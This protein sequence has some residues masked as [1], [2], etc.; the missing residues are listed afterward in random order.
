MS[1]LVVAEP[2]RA[3]R[4]RP[5]VVVDC[6]ALAAIIFDEPEAEIAA[7]RIAGHVLHAPQLLQAE[8]SQVALVKHRRGESHAMPALDQSAALPIDLHPL[9]MSAVVRLADRYA[10]TAYDAAYLWLAARLECP[11]ITFDRR[12]GRAALR[13]FDCD[14]D[15]SA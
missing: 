9:D 1:R 15:S 11:L 7:Q 10:L 3:F 8:L 14:G 12:L 13:H 2:A 5:P 6:S 4:I